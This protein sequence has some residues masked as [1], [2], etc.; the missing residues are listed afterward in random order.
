MDIRFCGTS[1]STVKRYMEI[2]PFCL[3]AVLSFRLS[4]LEAWCICWMKREITSCVTFFT[5]LFHFSRPPVRK[6][7][8]LTNPLEGSRN[9]IYKLLTGVSSSLA[10]KLPVWLTD[11]SDRFRKLFITYESSCRPCRS[12]TSFLIRNVRYGAKLAEKIP[13]H[14]RC[15]KS[16]C[17]HSNET[18]W[19]VGIAECVKILC[20]LFARSKL[21]WIVQLAGWYRRLG[22][23][24]KH[25]VHLAFTWCCCPLLLGEGW[26]EAGTCGTSWQMAARTCTF[27]TVHWRKSLLQT[28]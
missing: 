10:S 1:M 22:W 9:V 3:T 26:V 4:S 6:I 2:E 16:E 7:I 15:E 17:R 12:W 14:T 28:P 24:A 11:S 23:N 19:Y 8:A 25:S 20:C 27:T 21:E 18:G 5:I 13:E